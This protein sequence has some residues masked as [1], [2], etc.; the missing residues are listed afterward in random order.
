MRCY[1]TS[2]K[3]A[4]IKNIKN[5]GCWRG[6]GEKATFIPD[7]GNVNQYS[8]YEKPCEVSTKKKK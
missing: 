1:F 2:V 5:N 7:V 8:H 6:C 4:F 3:T